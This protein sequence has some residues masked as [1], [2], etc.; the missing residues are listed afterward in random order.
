MSDRDPRH[1]LSIDLIKVMRDM[2]LE[3]NIPMKDCLDT[4]AFMAATLCV[5]VPRQTPIGSLEQF[6]EF[7][8]RS[9]T[10][11]LLKKF[12]KEQQKKATMS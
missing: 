5:S 10:E 8:S 9:F 2:A 11:L 1:Q 6:T 12:E 3:R 7:F 4:V